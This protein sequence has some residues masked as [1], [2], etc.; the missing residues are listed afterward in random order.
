MEGRKTLDE[1]EGF[2]MYLTST[3]KYP[4]EYKGSLTIDLFEKYLPYAIALN[5]EKKWSKIFS[6]VLSKIKKGKGYVPVWYTPGTMR[7][8]SGSRFASSFGDSLSGSISSSSAAP[9]SSSGG[10]GGGW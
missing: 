8:F 9:G 3:E 2:I 10:G 7:G 4:L 5:V 6:G 1:I